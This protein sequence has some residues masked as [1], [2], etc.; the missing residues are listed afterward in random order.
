MEVSVLSCTQNADRLAAAAAR[1][2]YMEG[3]LVGVDL[4]DDDE[5]ERVMDGAASDTLDEFVERLIH[6]GHYGPFEHPQVT[7]AI[8]GVSRSCMAQITRHRHAT[9]DVQSMRYVNFEDAD[10]VWPPSFEKLDEQQQKEARGAYKDSL[11][12]YDM[13]SSWGVEEEDARMFL[14]IGTMVNMTATM[15]LRSLMHVIDMRHAGDAQWEARK[16]AEKMF[17]EA[18]EVAPITFEKYA[19]YAK[20]ASKKAP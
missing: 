8:E 11:E 9:F 13:V 3:S 19:E 12:A 5:F 6:R 16:L 2:D 10:V 20:G 7:F 1:G 17:E 18:K 4:S 14:P 15:N